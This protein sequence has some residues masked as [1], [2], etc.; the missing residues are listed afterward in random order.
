MSVDQRISYVALVIVRK[1]VKYIYR[2]KR[3]DMLSPLTD[4]Y[5]MTQRG[6]QRSN[7]TGYPNYGRVEVKSLKK[8]R[9]SKHQ[10]LM[11]KIMEDLRKSEPGF[12]VQI[13]LASTDNVP[14]L[15]L[16]SAIVRAAAKENIKVMTSSDDRYFY[17]WKKD[18]TTR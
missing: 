14:V 6:K 4:I 2:I 8:S 5:G 11:A 3:V 1:H 10:D 13:P 9:R 18:E 12:A 16:R 17:A 7:A 15:N